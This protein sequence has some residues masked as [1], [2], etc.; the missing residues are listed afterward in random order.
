M[1]FKEL[2]Y[3]INTRIEK[4]S[5][6]Y[7]SFGLFG[8]INYPLSYIMWHNVIKIYNPLAFRIVA[9]LLCLPLLLHKKW[10]A[11]LKKYLP[12]YW[13]MT[14]LYCVPFFETYIWLMDDSSAWKVNLI[15]ALFMFMLLVDW[16]LFIILSILGVSAAFGLY[17]L[18]A[19]SIHHIDN[20][21]LSLIT[22]MYIVAIFIAAIF[23]RNKEKL[24][25]ARLQSM[26]QVALNIAH[27][28][29]TPLASISLGVGGIYEYLNLTQN[30]KFSEEPSTLKSVLKHV[31]T[32]VS[33]AHNIINM[34]LANVSSTDKKNSFEICSIKECINAA[35]TRYPFSIGLE[36][37]VHW[38]NNDDFLFK[39]VELQTIHVLFNL[40][41]NALYYIKQA[42]KGEVKIWLEMT[43][44]YNYLH[45]L[46]T[47]AGIDKKSL[48]HIFD[49]HYTQ[50]KHGYGI[51]LSFSK[52]V[53]QSFGGDIYCN[54]EK[55][56]Y[57]EF[58]LA[59]PKIRTNS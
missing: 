18:T 30:E 24:N 33:L 17:F 55:G 39:G 1:T 19:T 4:S 14:V 36:E 52:S 47:G 13:C 57:T 7:F 20:Q 49:Q 25:Y 38:K 2:L 50:T 51:G 6:Q 32:E 11:L 59:F 42:D 8:S 12:I 48:R 27:E 46:D 31:D 45:F 3:K 37:K 58:I 26:K 21:T 15:L 5:P 10:P 34:L 22:Y 41:K 35:L 43:Y 28:L 9:L 40:L 44:K 53:M 56:E 54:S 29:R 23:S 16:F